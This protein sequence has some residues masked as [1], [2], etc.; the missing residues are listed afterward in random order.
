MTLYEHEIYEG[1]EIMGQEDRIMVHAYMC[2]DVRSAGTKRAQTCTVLIHAN[3][4][5]RDTLGI[6]IRKLNDGEGTICGAGR[7]RGL[8]VCM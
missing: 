1:H 4:R 5:Y 6:H 7:N 3:M 8:P 2:I